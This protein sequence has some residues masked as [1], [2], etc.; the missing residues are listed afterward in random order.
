AVYLPPAFY[1]EWAG[2]LGPPARYV[3]P[4][5][6]LAL[7]PLVCLAR[8][9]ATAI[10]LAAAPGWALSLCLG[11]WPEWGVNQVHGLARPFVVIGNGAIWEWHYLLPSMTRITYW[12]WV[13]TGGWL[14]LIGLL[15]VWLGNRPPLG[16]LSR[17]SLA[18]AGVVGLALALNWP[19]PSRYFEADSLKAV[20][21]ENV[22]EWTETPTEPVQRTQ[23]RVEAAHGSEL[24]P[25]ARDGDITTR[26]SSLSPQNRSMWLQI[27]L[28]RGSLI[29]HIRLLPGEAYWGMPFG[30]RY[31]ADQTDDLGG[32][33]P[34]ITA[35]LVY[36]IPWPVRF[37]RPVEGMRQEV[38]FAPP[39]EAK[40]VVFYMNHPNLGF[41]WELAEA[42]VFLL[43]E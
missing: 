16:W 29:D 22:Q 2:A 39:L 15:T 19:A 28:T 32:R 38:H 9:S 8:R 7:I 13:A 27:R 37:F 1:S 4:V 24:T 6:P 11:L 14:S 5:L 41:H 42:E 10:W 31:F 3:A 17:S 21:P 23:L 36:W 12:S 35:R 30:Y 33:P 43:P 26:W 18:L 25:L 40:R 20:S 34:E